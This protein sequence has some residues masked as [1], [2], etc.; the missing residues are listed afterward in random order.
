MM[1]EHDIQVA[2]MRWM[3]LQHR[4]AYKVTYATPNAAKR[5]PRQGAYMKAEGLKS[6]VPD[7][8]I[9]IP[10]KGFGALYIE[11]KREG[12]KLTDNQAEWLD[13]LNEAGN[14]AVLCVGFDAAKDTINS[15]LA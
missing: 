10:R 6:G 13:N 11:L 12:G 2:L 15:Y 14:M 9:P 7:I 1:K 5:T 4:K 8:C 3:R